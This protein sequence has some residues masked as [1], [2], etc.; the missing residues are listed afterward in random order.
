MAQPQFPAPTPGANPLYPH[1]LW[2]PPPL[3]LGWGVQKNTFQRGLGGVGVPTVCISTRIT[4]FTLA[5]RGPVA[6]G[7]PVL[8]G[9]HGRVAFT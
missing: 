1:C 5:L 2:A 6:Y 8:Y 3:F 9:G 4:P 7:G